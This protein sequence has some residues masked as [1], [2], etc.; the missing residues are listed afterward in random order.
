[1]LCCPALICI[2]HPLCAQCSI[3]IFCVQ[4]KHSV[5]DKSL[6]VATT[7][8]LGHRQAV[9]FQIFIRY[10]VHHRMMSQWRCSSSSMAPWA[11]N[12]CDLRLQSS[13]FT[14]AYRGRKWGGWGSGILRACR[15]ESRNEHCWN[16]STLLQ[17]RRSESRLGTA[18]SNLVALPT[19][20]SGKAFIVI[21]KCALYIFQGC[22]R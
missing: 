16:T 1:M 21:T 3:T 17:E 11:I 20:N 9:A 14:R 5:Y 8:K 13:T 2:K 12:H 4:G 19:L 7:G 18:C 15:G 22:S 6:C 10:V